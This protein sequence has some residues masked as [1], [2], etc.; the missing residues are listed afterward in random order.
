MD[1]WCC[2]EFCNNAE[3]V[4][5]GGSCWFE[6]GVEL[7]LQFFVRCAVAKPDT[8]AGYLVERCGVDPAV[9]AECRCLLASQQHGSP[10]FCHNALMHLIRRPGNGA[11]VGRAQSV[12]DAAGEHVS[13]AQARLHDAQAALA[14]AQEALRREE[15][16]LEQVRAR[17]EATP[18]A[19]DVY[20][21]EASARA[22]ADEGGASA[23]RHCPEMEGVE[24]EVEVGCLYA[25][26]QRASV[27]SS[28]MS[29]EACE[30]LREQDLW[31]EEQQME[32][33][34]T[35]CDVEAAYEHEW[36]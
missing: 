21:L 9:V 30:A 18:W 2:G 26:S 33:F 22:D 14:A 8:K 29:H 34:Y 4:S 17:G 13:L 35:Q 16:R 1:E 6:W 27:E 10:V 19:A 3:C 36:L 15:Q 12:R 5:A 24:S 25:V 20:M 31:E 11:N 28:I 32:E 7:V 23:A